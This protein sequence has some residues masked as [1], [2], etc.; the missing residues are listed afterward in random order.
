MELSS[1]ENGMWRPIKKIEEE[2]RYG[3]MDQDMMDSG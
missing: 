1:K 3:L 2:F